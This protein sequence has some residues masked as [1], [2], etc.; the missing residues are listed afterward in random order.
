M[1]V[2]GECGD[3]FTRNNNLERH[4]KQ[5]CHGSKKE[6]GELYIPTFSGSE[7][8]TGKPK[9]KETMA[10]IEKLVQQQRRIRRSR[11]PHRNQDS[12]PQK[13]KEEDQTTTKICSPTS[14]LKYIKPKSLG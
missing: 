2:C 12:P 8:G 13:K 9:S 14:I 6:K 5:S 1:F 7:F 10:K 4:K 3:N 11:S